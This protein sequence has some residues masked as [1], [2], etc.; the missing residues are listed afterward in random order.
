MTIFARRW[1]CGGVRR[2]P[3]SRTSR[4]RGSAIAQLEELRSRAL[5]E[6]VDADL[7]LGRHRELVGE[8]PRH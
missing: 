5:E 1:R 2:S 7:A 6:R 4:S 3:T 8:L